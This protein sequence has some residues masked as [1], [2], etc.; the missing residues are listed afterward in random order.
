MIGPVSYSPTDEADLRRIRH[1]VEQCEPFIQW[2]FYIPDDRPADKRRFCLWERSDGDLIGAAFIDGPPNEGSS[3]SYLM[4]AL[5]PK[6]RGEIESSIIQWGKNK[7]RELRPR[8]PI[9]TCRACRDDLIRIAAL[10]QHG[11]KCQEDEEIWVMALLLGKVVPDPQLPEGYVIR[12]FSAQGDA[13]EWVRLWNEVEKGSLAVEER[14]SW[15]NRSSYVPKLDLVV[16]APDGSLAAYCTCNL[17]R[18]DDRRLAEDSA[19]ILWLGTHPAFRRRGLARAMLRTVLRVFQSYGCS[20][21]LL[22]TYSTNAPAINLYKSHGFRT[23]Y[24]MLYYVAAI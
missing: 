11:F 9:L 17:F 22:S 8:S 12:P 19:W 13:E 14:L 4:F 21:V 2:F 1:L 23:V 20:K 5:H 3:T 18:S 15:L 16:V 6:A 10:E 24:R 7:A